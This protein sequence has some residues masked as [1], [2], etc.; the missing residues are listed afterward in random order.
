MSAF[1]GILLLTVLG[2]AVFFLVRRIRA[3]FQKPD[4]GGCSCCNKELK[5]AVKQRRESTAK[6]P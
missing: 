2:A 1:E 6:E 3:T 4:S 5:K